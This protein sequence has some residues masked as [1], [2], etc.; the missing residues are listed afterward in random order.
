MQVEYLR[1][2]GYV[3][4]GDRLIAYD[5]LGVECQRAGDADALPPA[6]VELVR[7]GIHIP[8]GQADEVHELEHPLFYLRLVCEHLLNM[9]GLGYEILNGE[10][11]I[12]RGEGVL[13][14]H[15]HLAVYVGLFL[16][17]RVKD[18]LAVIE[19]LALGGG[20]QA[21]NNP[22][23]GGLAA[24]GFT[25]HAERLLGGY[26]QVHVVHG[27]QKALTDL[28]VLLKALGF[29]NRCFHVSLPK[30]LYTYGT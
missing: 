30:R 11:G 21:E 1:L 15:L 20:Q 14:D 12:E 10:T 18:A 7:I 13:E 16:F 9:N 24:A 8:L 19:D 2:N 6:A 29:N 5:E 28:E 3:Q 22:A 17:P 23:E 25:D 27:V 26:C 4:G